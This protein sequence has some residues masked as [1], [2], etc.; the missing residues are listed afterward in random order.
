MRMKLKDSY[1]NL[2]AKVKERT[3]E[4]RSAQFQIV[5]QEKMASLGLMAAGIAHEIGNPLT[6]ISSLVQLMR[7]SCTDASSAENLETVL[8]HIK[9]ISKIVRELVDFSAPSSDKI[10]PTYVNSVIKSVVGIMRY[11]QRAKNVSFH[12][13]LEG[14]LPPIPLIADQL[15]QVLF[16]LLVNAVDAMENHGSDLYV[17]SRK[18]MNN[19]IIEIEDSGI[20]IP[21]ANITK[22]F[23][24]FF[25]TKEVGKGTG[26]GLS[27]SYG[28]IQ[29]FG[30][31]ISV[32][33]KVDEGTI[34]TISL[35]MEIMEEEG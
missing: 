8:E 5:H 22:I 31:K 33:S 23:E 32:K 16:N 25:T 28:I 30:G 13:Q 3:R 20:G 2:E 6:S 26:L 4:L 34:F 15:R 11:D 24:P 19:I 18:M 9:R 14:N 29:Q 7:R 10:E 35:P 21:E 1:E 17:R 12:L 27:V